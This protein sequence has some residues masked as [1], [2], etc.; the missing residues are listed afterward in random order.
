M[1]QADWLHIVTVACAFC[2]SAGGWLLLVLRVRPRLFWRRFPESVRAVIPQ[3]SR[4]E[5]L[6]GVLAGLPLFAMLIG[7]PVWAAAGVDRLHQGVASLLDLYLA[8]YL[9][10]MAF[11]LFDWLVLDELVVGLVRPRWLVP[12]GAEQIPIPFDHREHA[13]AFLKGTIA[14][15]VIA[16]GVAG[17]V[18]LAPGRIHW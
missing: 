5:R 12:K 9:T 13:V 18:Y 11:N 16:A 4:N 3:P 15:T 10:W 6:L 7:F 8:A 2:M 17:F 14:G 1:T